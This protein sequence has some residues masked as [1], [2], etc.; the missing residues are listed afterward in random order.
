MTDSPCPTAVVTGASSFVGVHLACAFAADGYQ[1]IA[2]HS[3]PRADY[4]GIQA[5]RLDRAAECC[6][7]TQ[8]DLTAPGALRALAEKTSP[9]VWVHHA[10]YATNY[11]SPDYDMARAKAVNVAPLHDLFAALSGTGAGVLITGS[12]AEYSDGDAADREDDLCRPS[13]PYGQ[14]KLAE[15]DTARR[16]SEQFAVPCRVG[17]LYIPF[18]PLDNPRKLLAETVTAL[19]AGRPVD[20]SPCTQRR[21]FIG[22]GDVTRAWRALAGDLK[23]GGFDI[24]NICAGEAIELRYLLISVARALNAD[25]ALLRFGARAMRP[26]EPT[27]SFG[28]NAKA[29]RL[30]DWTPRPLET[31]LNEDLV[32]TDGRLSTGTST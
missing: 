16:L 18:G 23:R 6:R 2:T 3:R 20:L 13:L 25:P 29:R 8:L 17:R 7:L 31:A 26:G 21:D 15:T 22:I 10:G 11:A 27:I 12:S 19:S 32:A 24:F 4:D 30:L 14:S 5:R 28:D 1:V 9:R